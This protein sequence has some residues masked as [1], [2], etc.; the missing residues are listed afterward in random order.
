MVIIANIPRKTR[1]LTVLFD[2][3]HQRLQ[4]F[5]D[6]F[7]SQ[8]CEKAACLLESICTVIFP[9]VEENIKIESKFLSN[10]TNKNNTRVWDGIKNN[11]NDLDICHFRREDRR[12]KKTRVSSTYYKN[13]IQL[14]QLFLIVSIQVCCLNTLHRYR[15]NSDN[16][17]LN[18]ITKKHHV[19]VSNKFHLYLTKDHLLHPTTFERWKP[20][21]KGY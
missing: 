7:W 17:I 15:K 11:V 9:K 8:P 20:A 2:G 13:I 16:R 12:M 3:V 5:R 10:L 1:L 4:R 19:T 14:I 21:A 18:L 6:T